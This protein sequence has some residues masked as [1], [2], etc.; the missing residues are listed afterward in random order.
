MLGEQELLEGEEVLGAADWIANGLRIEETKCVCITL[1]KLAELTFSRISVA[2]AARRL[3][4]TGGTQAR[5]SVVQQRQK[6]ASAILAF[7]R[8]GRKHIPG[9][10]P[11]HGGDLLMDTTD[12]GAQWDEVS[13]DSG[14][15]GTDLH[16]DRPELH[17]LALLS[18]FGTRF[19]V[20]H[21]LEDLMLKECQLREGQMN[22]ALQGIRTGIGYKSLLYRAK[23]R[24][25][26]SYR[27]KLRS[28]DDVH[29]ADEGVRKYVRIYTQSRAAMERLF[30]VE[31]AEDASLLDIFR[32]RYREIKKEDL[33]ASTAVLEA[34]TPGLRNEHSAWFW[35]VSDT[36][37]GAGSDWTQR[38]TFRRC[39]STRQY[40]DAGPV[41]RR[42]L[43]LR[44]YARKQRWD[45][46]I[47]LVPFEMECTV[48]SFQ[49]W[50]AEWEEWEAGS[51][52]PGHSAF[53]F[54]QIAI[55]KSLGEHAKASFATAQSVFSP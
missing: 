5:L 37:S 34:F 27:A 55:W 14:A 7:H 33:K 48:R 11:G 40:D 25:A 18:T 44:A 12:F 32:S 41:D 50:A 42:M 46:E 53:A 38:C 13:E 3:T 4:A 8:S 29:V 19:L 24:N 10:M 16:A 36:E 35:N 31:K 17:P 39:S 43:W 15:D 1:D 28:F 47:V 52:T 26:S 9:G 51:Q 22:D 45:E 30:D 21:G 49:K 6:L 2:H 23:V 54:K 20:R